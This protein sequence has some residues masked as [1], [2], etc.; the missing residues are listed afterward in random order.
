MINEIFC[1]KNNHKKVCLLTLDIT[2]AFDTVCHQILLYKLYR[3]GLDWNSILWFTSYL[4]NRKQFVK[5]KDKISDM[6][7]LKVSVPQGSILGPLLFS[8]YLNDL[9]EIDLNG[10]IVFYADDCSIVYSSES[11]EKL[12]LKVSS[13]LNK[14]DE[15]MTKNRLTI[16]VK[17]SN[18]LLIDFSGRH[19]TDLSLK[20]GE[21]SLQ[22]V[23]ETKVLGITID[24]RLAFKSHI[25]YLCSKITSR[26]GLI[27][28]LKQFL[29]KKY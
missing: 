21:N 5:E 19:P 10:Q 9:S 23:Y 2:K 17:K 28:R 14:I 22:R 16:N 15:W 27:S 29:P 7:E 6:K 20:I 1:Q 12:E 26:I 4:Q 18:Y 13:S 25:N 11:Y 3:L 24:D 8:I